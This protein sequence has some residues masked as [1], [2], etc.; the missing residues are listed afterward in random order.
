MNKF[1]KALALFGAGSII[2]TVTQ[3]VKGKLGAILLGV[4][5]VGVLNQLTNAW[6]LLYT[7]SGL[8][9]YNNIVRELSIAYSENNSEALNRQ[10]STSLLFLTA[11]SLTTTGIAVAFPSFI[12]NILFADGGERSWLVALIFWSVPFAVVSQIYAGLFNASRMVRL[13]V[14]IQVVSDLIG[15]ILFVILVFFGQMWGA[16]F[17]FGLSNVIKLI[18]QIISVQRNSDIALLRSFTAVFSTSELKGG[19]GYGFSGLLL[20]STGI[21]ATTVVSRWIIENVGT[22][23]N[24]LFSVAWKVCSLYFGAIYASASGYY[25]PSL[26]AAKSQGELISKITEAVTIHVFDGAPIAYYNN[27]WRRNYVAAI[28]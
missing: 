25:Y 8:G 3:V 15:M 13:V 20:V 2:G 17:A 12:S 7:L 27:W 28:Y 10:L 11:F 6:G 26:S 4:E 5:G 24:G 14:G 18:V 16:I 22:Q 1:A 23:A 9:L 19:W 21:F